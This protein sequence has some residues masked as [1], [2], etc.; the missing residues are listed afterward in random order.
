MLKLK[1]NSKR[2]PYGGHHYPEY[3][4]MFKGE[5]F[6]EVVKKVKE[7]RI[8][9]NISLGNPEQDVL[10]FYVSHWPWLVEEDHE[11]VEDEIPDQFREWRL[12]IQS[13][14]R[15]PPTKLVTPTEAKLRWKVCET[16]P[17]NE[18]FKHEES[19]ESSEITRRAFLLRRGLDAPDYLG[20]CACFKTDLGSLSYFD[21]PAKYVKPTSVEK[22]GNCWVS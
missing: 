6:A 7:F 12:W 10:V 2:A 22:P 3:G 19:Q 18:Q 9:N 17:Y 14:W 11:S 8:S 1:P 16:C 15:T 20:F 13:T 4:M 21:S 5:S